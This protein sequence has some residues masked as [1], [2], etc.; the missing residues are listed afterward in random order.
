MVDREEGAAETF[1]DAGVPFKSLF[2]ASEF[3]KDDA[4]PAAKKIA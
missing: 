1:K 4:K 3:L 2:K